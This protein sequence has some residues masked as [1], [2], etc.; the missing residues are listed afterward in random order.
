EAALV[1]VLLCVLATI[2]LLAVYRV[3]G[4]RFWLEGLRYLM[5]VNARGQPAFLCGRY[6]DQGWWYYFPVAFMLKTPVLTLA[7]IAASLVLFRRG[8]PLRRRETLFLG[9]PVVVV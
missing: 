8:R 6:S 3:H 4:G 2:V 7:A 1:V 5:K 9:I